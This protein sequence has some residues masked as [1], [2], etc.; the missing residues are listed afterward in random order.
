VV[1]SVDRFIKDAGELINNGIMSMTESFEI[2][3]SEMIKVRKLALRGTR[4]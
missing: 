2:I 3:A 4:K 1:D